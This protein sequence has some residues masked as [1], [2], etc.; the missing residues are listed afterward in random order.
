[1]FKNPDINEVQSPRENYLFR[2]HDHAELTLKRAFDSNSLAHSWLI[3]G[4]KG[5]GKATL[6]YR[7]AR[8]VL[9]SGNLGGL[10]TD[11]PEFLKKDILIENGPSNIETGPLY[12]SP[13]HSVFKRVAAGGHADFMSVERSINEKT[14]KLRTEIVVDDVRSIGNFFNLTAGEGGWRIVVIDCA[15]EMNL[16]AANAV[17]KVLEE[18]PPRSLLLLVS[19]N[20]GKLLGTIRSRCR[21]LSLQPLE[22]DFVYSL[23]QSWLLDFDKVSIE[24]LATIADGSPGRALALASDGGVSIYQDMMSL[25]GT[26]PKLD[27]ASLHAFSGRLGKPGSDDAFR[28]ISELIRWWLARMILAKGRGEGSFTI[29]TE[30][31]KTFMDKIG[32]VVS[33]ER[34]FELW[35]KINRLLN[36]TDQI[37]L[38]QKQVVLNI[39]LLLENSF[40]S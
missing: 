24:T 19:H 25:L 2:G 20:P 34:W 29:L 11:S 9:S 14:G 38:D 36:K 27:V 28:T 39:F 40:Q 37:N 7:F 12:I 26:L 31:E 18:P 17:L 6:A 22:R 15:D 32:N 1:M 5:I 3:S 13:N 16:N 10:N 4:P 8:Y 35:E 33:L 21:K 30:P 23:L